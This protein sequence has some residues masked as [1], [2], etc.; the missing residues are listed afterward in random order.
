M[1]CRTY[2]IQRVIGESRMSFSRGSVFSFGSRCQLGEV[3][4]EVCVSAELNCLEEWQKNVFQ[5]LHK[6]CLSP[7]SVRINANLAEV[8]EALRE[9]V[10]R[11]YAGEV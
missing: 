7:A 10:P 8:S 5:L 6:N 1:A 9:I 11:R 4:T 2:S 3:M